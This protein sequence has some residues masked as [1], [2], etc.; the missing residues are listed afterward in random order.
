MAKFSVFI[1]ITVMSAG[2]VNAQTG[3][4]ELSVRDTS[5]N[6]YFQK[7]GAENS[8][9]VREIAI[10]GNKKT[11][12]SIIL[13]ELSFA[14]GETY[15]LSE[16]VKK[17]EVARKQL[18]NTALFHEVVVALKSF[19]GNYVDILI[20]VK[21]RWY[22]FPVPYIKF[23]DR[24]IN[25]WIVEQN[26]KLDRVNY[27]LKFLYNNVSG[28][29]DKLNLYLINGYTKQISLSYDR[30]YIDKN[31]KWGINTGIAIGRNREINYNTINDKQVFFKDT[32][33]FV[34]SFFRVY[35]GATYRPAIKT[36]HSFGISYIVENVS[37][38]IVALNPSYFTDE[39]NRIS[40]PEI[41]YTL[42]YIDVDYNP[43]PLKGYIAE[44]Y[45]AKRGFTNVINMW[46][47]SAKAS[48]SWEIAKKTYFGVKLAGAIK[49]PFSQPY[50]NQRLLGYSDFFLQGYEYYVMDGV[51]GG[52]TKASLSREILNLGF[53]VKRKKDVIPYRIPFRAYAKTFVNAGYAYNP[54][55][56]TNKLNNR[57]LY[58]AGVGID[59]IT[60]YDFTLKFEWTFNL[61]GENGLYLH[62]KSYF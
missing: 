21:E 44:L 19:E 62:R 55:P 45:F 39:R 32:N 46:L 33:N 34:R 54:D 58:S 15:A 38:T 40:F 5:I 51:A 26:A 60:H 4:S 36:R 59:I 23:V 7:P 28:R 42:S 61:L 49:F 27:G 52:Y 16:L 12:E 43:Y 56:G 13:R 9:I 50:F 1:F 48:G 6:K 24:N 20:A 41:Y 3:M 37:D 30:P 25:Q 53:H 11:K 10:S 22:L 35:G 18:L 57:M 29:N 2:F 14:S 8:F 47:L 31:M 17:F